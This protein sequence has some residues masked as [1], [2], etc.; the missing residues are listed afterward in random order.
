MLIKKKYVSKEQGMIKKKG[1]SIFNISKKCIRY[2]LQRDRV[3]YGDF[4]KVMYYARWE[5]MYV[6]NKQKILI[7]EKIVRNKFIYISF[8]WGIYCD[9]LIYCIM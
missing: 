3:L 5:K 4:D 1:R 2:N 7:I 8:W 6:R 9:M